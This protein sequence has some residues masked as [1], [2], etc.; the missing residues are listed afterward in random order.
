MQTTTS[1]NGERRV[2]AA[3]D[4][5]PFLDPDQNSLLR[6]SLNCALTDQGSAGA[7]AVAVALLNGLLE[8]QQTRQL[9]ERLDLDALDAQRLVDAVIQQVHNLPE[10]Q[11]VLAEGPATGQRLLRDLAARKS[12]RVVR[13]IDETVRLATAEPLEVLRT[14]LHER[15]QDAPLTCLDGLEEI[16]RLLRDYAFPAPDYASHSR[17]AAGLRSIDAVERAPG[18]GKLKERLAA[19]LARQCEHELEQAFK[20]SALELISG[21]LRKGV[22]G[23]LALVDDLRARQMAYRRNTDEVRGTL[24][25][26]HAEAKQRTV[27]ARSSVFLELPTPSCEQLL[28]GIRDNLKCADQAALAAQFQDKLHF[29]LNETARQRRPFITTPATLTDLLI[30]MPAADV[31]E[32]VHEVVA[33]LISGL[34]SVY[35]AVRSTGVAVVARELFERAEPLCQ[36]SARTD[37]RL[38]VEPHTDLIVRLPVA[39]GPDDAE[40]QELLRQEFRELHRAPQF[41]AE[42]LDSEI[43]VIRTL[44]GF[45]IG[46]ESDNE[47][48]LVDYA[49]SADQGHHPH[50]FGILPDAPIGRPLP[51]LLALARHFQPRQG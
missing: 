37:I 12:L 5:L 17:L 6:M 30:Q 16:A 32:G 51:Q 50:L 47:S 9:H 14:R 13:R 46:I 49:A 29:A 45:P 34:H 4:L 2:D 33:D 8:E 22:A 1:R 20:A 31:A 25:R 35:T 41:V 10:V 15:L 7:Q 28:S 3:L 40:I 36:L 48:M 42:S 18:I 23:L 39:R 38:N 27:H 19:T 11:E 24:Q 26:Q 43:A 21:E 44:V